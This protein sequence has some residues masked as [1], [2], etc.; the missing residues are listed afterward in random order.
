MAKISFLKSQKIELRRYWLGCLVEFAS[1]SLDNSFKESLLNVANKVNNITRLQ[2]I[3]NR[4][5]ATDSC[6]N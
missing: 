3:F 6:T 1:G 4:Y 5:Y 2:Y